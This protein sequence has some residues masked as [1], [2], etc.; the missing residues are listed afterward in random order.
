MRRLLIVSPVAGFWTSKACSPVVG[1][2]EAPLPAEAF[3]VLVVDSTIVS[4]AVAG[5]SA[6]L[7]SEAARGPGRSAHGAGA[8]AMR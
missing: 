2:A 3:S 4:F 5:C 6:R 1:A 7:Y 8:G